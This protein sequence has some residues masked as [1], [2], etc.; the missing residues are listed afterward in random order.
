MNKLIIAL[1][2][3]ALLVY[4]AMNSIYTVSEVEQVIITQFGK[5]VGSPVTSAGLKLKAPFIQEVN[6]IDKRVLERTSC[7]SRSIFSPAGGSSIPC[8]TFCACVM[9]VARNRAWMTFSAARP[10]MRSPSTS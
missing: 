9:S 8:S 10:A 7:T 3:V 4:V 2:A 6:P 1:G 5:P